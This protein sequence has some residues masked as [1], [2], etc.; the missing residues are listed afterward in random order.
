MFTLLIFTYRVSLAWALFHEGIELVGEYSVS[1]TV[2]E[3]S[4][5]GD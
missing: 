1:G 2:K 4:T 3:V 5:N